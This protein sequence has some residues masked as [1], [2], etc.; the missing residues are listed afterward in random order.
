MGAA[1]SGS[2]TDAASHSGPSWSR[3]A[4]TIPTSLAIINDIFRD[5]AS[6]LVPS[7][8]GAARSGLESPIGPSP[9]GFLL[10]SSGGGRSS[11]STSRSACI[12]F[13]GPRLVI[14]DSKNPH[15]QRPDPVG[16]ALSI[17]GLV[18]LL[19]AIIEA[20]P[21]LDLRDR[22]GGGAGQCRCTRGFVSWESR[23][24]HPM[25]KLEFFRDR[26]FSVALAAEC[27][28]CSGSWGHC[29]CRRSSS[30]STLGSRLSRP[31]SGSS[32]RRHDCRSAQRCPPWPLAWWASSSPLHPVSCRSRPACGR[33]R[34]SS[35]FDTTYGDVVLGLLLIGGLG[36]RTHAATATNSVIGSVP[37]GDSGMGSA[38]N[39]WR[40][41]SAAR[42]VSRSSAV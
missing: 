2:V 16:A 24:T 32:D 37:Q 17:A 40:S 8:S 33:S 19:W 9:V 18:L 20:R 31:A 14:P 22:G 6:V 30:N 3:C 26:R 41:K 38:S 36:C 39:T 29:S 28:R 5:R 21:G 10:S 35:R 11:W 15:V 13:L 4:L 25:L 12:G 27:W 1:L 42:W 34:A 7:A 23:S